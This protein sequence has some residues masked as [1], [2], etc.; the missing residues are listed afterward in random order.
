LCLLQLA[1]T[2]ETLV[3]KRAAFNL[4]VWLSETARGRKV[5]S[6]AFL[7]RLSTRDKVTGL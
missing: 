3:A 6:A 7:C 4:V 2:G 1:L 5:E